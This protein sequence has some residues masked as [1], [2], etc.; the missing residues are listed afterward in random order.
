MSEYTNYFAVK[1]D[2]KQFVK[3]KLNEAKILSIINAD[4]SD[5]WFADEYKRNGKIQWVTVEAPAI[6]IDEY[7]DR[8]ND[9]KSLFANLMWFFQEE[10]GRDWRALIYSNNTE[11]SITVYENEVVSFTD[12]EMTVISSLFSKD[13]TEIK[14]LLYPGKGSEF[15]NFVGVPYMEMSDQNQIPESIIRD[16]QYSFLV[17]ELNH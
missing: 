2:S 17:D 1:A 5:F 16:N 6:F 12:T 11:I 8:F 14:P 15:L 3:C 13:F 7:K 9:L 4:E 10:N